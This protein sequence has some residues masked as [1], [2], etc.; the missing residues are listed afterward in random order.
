MIILGVAISV[1]LVLVVGIA[2]GRKIDGDSSNYLVAGRRYALVCVTTGDHYVA[3]TNTDN[4][5]VQGTFFVS[6]DGAFFAGN[7]EDYPAWL[8]EAFGK[9]ELLRRAEKMCEME[10]NELNDWELEDWYED[11]SPARRIELDSRNDEMG[12]M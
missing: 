5:V 10:P 6:T 7:L 9:P 12:G 3:M 1:V 11:G 8:R 4:G 2:V